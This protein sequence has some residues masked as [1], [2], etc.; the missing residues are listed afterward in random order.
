MKHE[1]DRHHRVRPNAEM[2]ELVDETLLRAALQCGTWEGRDMIIH[3]IRLGFATNSSSSHS[4]VF[5]R[6][7]RD[8]VDG[9]EYGWEQ[10]TIASDKSKLDYLGQ[11]LYGCISQEMGSD[12]AANVVQAWCTDANGVSRIK[13]S[14]LEGGYVDHQSAW[15]LPKSWDGKGVDREFFDDLKTFML[16][17]DLVVL[18]G[19]DNDGEHPLAG[20]GAFQLATQHYSMCGNVVAKKDPSGF[21]SMFNRSSGA[22]FRFSFGDYGIVKHPN[23]SSAPELVDLKITDYCDRGCAY[24]YQGSTTRGKH[25]TWKTIVDV[26]T[27]LAKLRVFE[28]AIGG[29]EPMKHPEFMNVLRHARSVGIVPNFTTR[30]TAWIGE[31]IAHDIAKLVGGIGFS[32]ESAAVV[33]EIAQAVKASKMFGP[34]GISN[35]VVMQVVVGAVPDDELVAIANACHEEHIGVLLLGFKHTKRGRTFGRSLENVV[36][37]KW[38]DMLTS[39]KKRWRR[40]GVDT[41]LISQF[42]KQLTPY[43]EGM[44]DE[45]D[46]DDEDDDAGSTCAFYTK[47]EGAFSMYVDAVARKLG[48]SSYCKP[49]EM[50]P[51]ENIGE[52]F[53]AMVPR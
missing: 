7:C 48:P 23:K 43:I 38:I 51:I 12:V 32:V 22:K 49:S 16:K 19:N 1:G 18:G 24:C 40:I 47:E 3:N 46:E 14:A 33:R 30:E 2:T 8:D 28:V 13:R 52:Q 25:A 44:R 26:L 6:G 17:E 50:Q 41:A 5:L 42:G 4:L 9:N 35:R 11:Q 15:H 27:E 53:K 29:G 10:F 34:Y 31:P 45:D 36:S 39:D 21:W 37:S 20:E